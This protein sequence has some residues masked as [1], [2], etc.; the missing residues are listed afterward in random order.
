[1]KFQKGQSG[2]PNGRPPGCTNKRSQLAKL[3]EPHAEALI[4]KAVELALS[5]DTHALRLCLD[6]L[7]PKIQPCSADTTEDEAELRIEML[8]L[9]KELDEKNKQDY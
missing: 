9:R 1:M 5:G 6:R 7:I 3:L 2:N 4:N 8:A